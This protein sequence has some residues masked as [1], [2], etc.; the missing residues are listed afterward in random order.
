MSTES[1]DMI[2]IR[3][4]A[5]IR[6]FHRVQLC[7]VKSSDYLRLARQLVPNP[8]HVEA[9]ADGFMLVVITP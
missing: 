6:S 7:S 3:A 5:K 4:N 2:S 8:N 1:I 9:R